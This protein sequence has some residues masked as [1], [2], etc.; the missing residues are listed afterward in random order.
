MHVHVN[1]GSLIAGSLL[2]SY[3]LSH[4]QQGEED[5]GKK[6]PTEPGEK[7]HWRF[8]SASLPLLPHNT[9]RRWHKPVDTGRRTDSC[10]VIFRETPENSV[11][12]SAPG[13][14][15]DRN[16]NNSAATWCSAAAVQRRPRG[17][18]TRSR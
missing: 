7:S 6:Y 13:H 5:G 17:V 8:L 16:P 18:P 12:P 3:S 11:D 14:T 2:G 10:L 4:V 15:S 9:E 1:D